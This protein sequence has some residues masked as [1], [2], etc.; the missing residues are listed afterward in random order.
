MRSVWLGF[1]VLVLLA[2]RPPLALGADQSKDE[3]L[4]R[5]V[6]DAQQ[7]SWNRH[8]MH[9][10][11]ALFSDN[12]DVVNVLGWWWKDREELEAKLTRAHK[13]VF[14]K[15]A[16]NIGEVDV[17]FLSPQIAV[18]HAQWQMVGAMSPDGTL[19]HIPE[20][21]IQTQ[22]LQKIGGKWLIVAFQNTNGFPEKDFPLPPQQP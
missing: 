22:V 8:D 6:E 12:A 16:L 4:I 11:A 13:F 17:K 19:S 21:G 3:A 7:E 1:A 10:Y 2:A 18:V 15:S 9:A 14:Q 5:K 20:T